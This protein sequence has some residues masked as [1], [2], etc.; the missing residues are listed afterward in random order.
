[1]SDGSNDS[2]KEGNQLKE[3]NGVSLKERVGLEMEVANNLPLRLYLMLEFFV[4]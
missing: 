2:S 1:M 4:P 3:Y